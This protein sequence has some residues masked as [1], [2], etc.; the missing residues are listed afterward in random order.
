MVGLVCC[1][2]RWI[3]LQVPGNGYLSI[4]C[5]HCARW[6]Q[7]ERSISRGS[8]LAHSLGLHCMRYLL[9]TQ[10]SQAKQRLLQFCA[11]GI[12]VP[13][14]GDRDVTLIH[15]VEDR[16]CVWQLNNLIELSYQV[17]LIEGPPAWSGR[18]KHSYGHLLFLELASGVHDVQ[19]QIANPQVIPH[20]TRCEGLLKVLSRV[21]FDLPAHLKGMVSALLQKAGEAIQS[22]TLLP[23]K[24]GTSEMCNPRQK[25]N[26]RLPLLL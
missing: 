21:S 22:C 11:T 19:I 17:V 6:Q 3:S 23:S 12:D 16:L 4:P 20:G 26:F 7:V 2:I 1:I 5:E 8:Q 14:T 13:C 15:C 25:L 10:H 9:S 18:A 24:E